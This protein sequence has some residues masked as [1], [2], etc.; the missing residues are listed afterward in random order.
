MKAKRGDILFAQKTFYKHYGVYV[1]NRE[2]IHYRTED[3]ND[4]DPSHAK[5]IKTSIEEFSQ[6][7]EVYIDRSNDNLRNSYEET[8]HLAELL[9]DTGLGEY[10]LFSNNCEHFANF[11]KYGHNASKQIVEVRS[12][13]L[14]QVGGNVLIKYGVPIVTESL[15]PIV[16]TNIVTAIGKQL[17][18]NKKKKSDFIK[19]DIYNDLE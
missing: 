10:R 12:N 4:N 9:L 1:G 19:I 15:L 18:D 7:S 5:I 14:G 17:L 8:A 3:Y 11:C 6:I 13:L 16:I 2:V